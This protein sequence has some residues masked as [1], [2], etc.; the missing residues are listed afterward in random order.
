MSTEE[1]ASWAYAQMINI[2]DPTHLKLLLAEG[3]VYE[4]QKVLQPLKS[5]QKFLEFIYLKLLM[6]Q[7]EN[8]IVFTEIGTITVCETANLGLQSYGQND[9]ENL[10]ALVLVKL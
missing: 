3:F 2:L 7:N 1:K 8:A 6:I 9:E 10:L 4:L 5:K